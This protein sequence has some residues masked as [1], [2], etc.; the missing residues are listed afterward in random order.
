[1]GIVDNVMSIYAN[2]PA[3]AT[4]GAIT[5]ARISTL[6]EWNAATEGL[7]FTTVDPTT[8]GLDA[9]S[10]FTTVFIGAEYDVFGWNPG[11]LGIASNIDFASEELADNALVLAQ[12]FAGYATASATTTRLNQYSRLL[13]NTVAHELGHTLGLNHQPT[14]PMLQSDLLIPDDPDNNEATP[15]DSNLGYA[16]MAYHYLED[17]IAQLQELGTAPLDMFE[18]PVGNVDTADLL[19]KWLS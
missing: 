17:D 8:W 3:T 19:V 12:N 7:Y 10:D 15:D 6:A 11:L 14:Y 18:F 4:F 5:V 1:V 16:L 13:A 9:E 2:T